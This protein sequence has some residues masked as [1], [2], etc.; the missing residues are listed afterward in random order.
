MVDKYCLT[1]VGATVGFKDLTS[2]VLSVE[3]WQCLV[4]HGFTHL[5]VQTGPDIAWAS[6]QLESLKQ[7]I[8]EG[9]SIDVFESRKNLLKEEMMLCKA[10]DGSRQAGLVICHAGKYPALLR[11]Y[12]AGN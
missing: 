6:Q 7:E 5:R 3:F 1:T 8:P 12:C 11:L 2:S 9:L 4:Q 10:Q